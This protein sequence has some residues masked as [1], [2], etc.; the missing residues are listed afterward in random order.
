M[1][2]RI[3]AKIEPFKSLLTVRR[4]ILTH[5][6][7]DGSQIR[8]GRIKSFVPS[9]AMILNRFQKTSSNASSTLVLYS[10][11]VV[12]YRVPEASS[13]IVFVTCFTKPLCFFESTS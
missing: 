1:D 2:G 12:P 13:V 3:R 9:F 7:I 8:R 11:I 6:A 10:N 4:D 5:L